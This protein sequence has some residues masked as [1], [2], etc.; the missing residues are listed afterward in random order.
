M[1]SKTLFPALQQWKALTKQAVMKTLEAF[2]SFYQFV[3]YEP[4]KP[5]IQ[6]SFSNDEVIHASK[7]NHSLYKHSFVLEQGFD[8]T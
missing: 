6:G 1:L 8:Q 3:I 4:K 5:Y 7:Q 2:N